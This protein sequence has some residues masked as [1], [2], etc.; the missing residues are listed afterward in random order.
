MLSY[1]QCNIQES[2]PKKRARRYY[3]KT[4]AERAVER[5]F[6][7]FIKY[8]KE[9]DERFEKREQERWEREKE[10][11]EKNIEEER[12]QKINAGKDL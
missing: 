7:S 3:M 4:K 9:A 10:L 6:D 5:A 12:K 2:R 8:E 11:E 1:I